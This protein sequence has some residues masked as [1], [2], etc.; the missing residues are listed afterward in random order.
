MRHDDDTTRHEGPTF[1]CVGCGRTTHDPETFA[2]TSIGT[3]S[4]CGESHAVSVPV[5][6]LCDDNPATLD[7]ARREFADIL[8]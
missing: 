6:S 2:W 1:E 4:S 5:C 7:S 3:H 8:D